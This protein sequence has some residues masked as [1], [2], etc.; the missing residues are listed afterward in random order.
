MFPASWWYN[1]RRVYGQAMRVPLS[2]NLLVSQP[3]CYR[4]RDG[5]LL[6][7]TYLIKHRSNTSWVLDSA[8]S[9]EAG[10]SWS[11]LDE[12]C[13]WTW[14][15]NIWRAAAS[16]RSFSAFIWTFAPICCYPDLRPGL[17]SS[18]GLIS[19]STE[20]SFKPSRA[21][22]F[23]EN[24]EAQIRNRLRWLVRGCCGRMRPLAMWH[25]VS[26]C[27]WRHRHGSALNTRAL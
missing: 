10:A 16:W 3:V 18:S 6:D 7:I 20:P 1:S 21:R 2:K 5:A 22:A 11:N 19:K 17:N 9:A 25:C 8:E 12:T 24:Q 15:F 26:F 14:A 13:F 23:P 4:S 27:V